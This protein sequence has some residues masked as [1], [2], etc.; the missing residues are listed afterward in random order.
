MDHLKARLFQPVVPHSPLSV[1]EPTPGNGKGSIKLILPVQKHLDSRKNK[2]KKEPD[3]AKSQADPWPV[4]ST[5]SSRHLLCIP[6]LQVEWLST[7][8][9][10]IAFYVLPSPSTSISPSILIWLPE[11]GR[12]GIITRCIS[13][14]WLEKKITTSLIASNNIVLLPYSSG[15]QMPQMGLP[16]LKS[17]CQQGRVSF[18][19]L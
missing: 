19:R 12:A 6:S 11:E 17:R 5:P 14:L 3:S 16:G 9:S 10:S 15:C 13:F 4:L 2:N 8:L 18:W 7:P 1:Q